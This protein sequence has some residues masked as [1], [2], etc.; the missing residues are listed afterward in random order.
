[1][2]KTVSLLLIV[3][4]CLLEMSGFASKPAAADAAP[5]ES[6]EQAQPFSYLHDPRLNPYAM[7]DIVED[8]E[9]PYGFRPS[10]TG[11]LKQFG[12]YDWHDPATVEANRA[13]RL[14]YH[15]NFSELYDQLG[16]MYAQDATMEE[17]ARAISERRNQLRIKSYDGNPEG[18]AKMKARNLEKYGRE[19]GP[20]PDQLFE[21]KGSWEAVL[22]GALSVNSG[23]DACLGLYDDY[24]D[25]YVLMGQIEDDGKESPGT[26]AVESE[27]TERGEN[28]QDMPDDADDADQVAAVILHTNDVHVAFQDNIGYDGLALYKKELEEQYDH[29]LLIDAGDAIQGAPIGAI[30][31]GAEPI[32]MMN[33][34]GYDLAVPG[35]HEFDYGFEALD[36]CAEE[37]DCGYTCAN[38]C[39]TGGETVFRPWRILEAGDL[40]IGFVGAVTPDT[41]TKSVIKDVLNE[42]GEPMYDFLADETGERLCA[43]LQKAIDEM[44]QA[45]ADYVILVSHLGSNESITA[46]FR[47]DAVVGRL[48]GLDLVIDGHAHETFSRTVTDGEGR[49]IPIAETGVNLNA[50]GQIKI[51]RDGRLE[52]TLIDR[53]PESADIPFEIVTRRGVERFVD[54]EMKQFLDDIVA[55]YAPVMDRKI[56]EAPCEFLVRDDVDGDR[57]SRAMENGLCDLV[58]DAYRAVGKS[59]IGFV[60]AGSVRNGLPAGTVTYNSVLNMLPYSNDI[61]TVKLSGQT[62]LDVLEFGVSRLPEISALFPQVS[63][64][65]FRVDTGIESSVRVDEKNQFVSVDGPR[66]VSDVTVDGRPLDP[67]AEYTLSASSFVTECGD[68]FT[69]FEDA[70]LLSRTMLVDNEAVMQYIEEELGGVIPESYQHPQGRIIMAEDEQSL[71]AAA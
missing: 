44:R 63:G 37:M 15:D 8:E 54:P 58:A 23:M 27:G 36:N 28:E 14:A 55:S 68:G 6:A 67:D 71:A 3:F 61:V 45:G 64:I 51:Y 48:T 59:Q 22:V 69:M 4:L 31:K 66:R 35:N 21:E 38:F 42:V 62:L 33:R 60:N 57:I 43:G 7:A 20:L 5:A 52:Q 46:Q 16:K 17:I 11:N 13:K 19:E 26:F 49:Q 18:L 12:E 40:K 50:I 9:A 56:G 32:R 41:F 39:V 34:L 65:S 70:E 24:Y 30:S 47:S 1:M 10:E 53:V 29:V 2:K 25:L